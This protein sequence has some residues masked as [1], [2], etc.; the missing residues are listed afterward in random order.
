MKYA[1][2]LLNLDFLP[3][4]KETYLFMPTETERSRT[5]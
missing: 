4:I 2:M 5:S 1:S 3:K